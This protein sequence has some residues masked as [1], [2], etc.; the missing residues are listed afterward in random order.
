MRAKECTHTICIRIWEKKKSKSIYIK[1]SSLAC[2]C[3]SAV[4]DNGTALFSCIWQRQSN[5]SRCANGYINPRSGRIY[6]DL[7]NEII[8]F[9]ASFDIM[10]T[11]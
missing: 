1:K 7:S 11:K 10:E 8:R 6:K 2:A 4:V 9:V 3:D 5:V